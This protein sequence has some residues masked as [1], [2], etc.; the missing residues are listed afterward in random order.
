MNLKKAVAGRQ[1]LAEVQK[2]FADWRDR[3]RQGCKIP[4]QLWQAAVQLSDRHL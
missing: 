1:S 3:R 4:K 2:Q